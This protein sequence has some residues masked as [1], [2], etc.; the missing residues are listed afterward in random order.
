MSKHVA[1]L[2][3]LAQGERRE[4]TSSLRD[5]DRLEPAARAAWAARRRGRGGGGRARPALRA[6]RRL[7]LDDQSSGGRRGPG[8]RQCRG[9]GREPARAPGNASCPQG[10]RTRVRASAGQTLVRPGAR[11]RPPRLGRRPLALANPGHSPSP[12][13]GTAVHA[14]PAGRNRAALAGTRRPERKATRGPPWQAAAKALGAP[15]RGPLAQSVEQLTFNQRVAGS[16]PARLTPCPQLR[17]A[18]M[19]RR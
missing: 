15:S 12:A 16:S 3:D 1:P 9:D 13:R 7:A 10:D 5:R 8:L 6:V 11:P 19:A 14:A 17:W 2:H 4:A 18:V